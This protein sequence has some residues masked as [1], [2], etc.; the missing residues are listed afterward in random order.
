MKPKQF[1]FWYTKHL[2]TVTVS[3]TN[4]N[5]LKIKHFRQFKFNKRN[6]WEPEKS[7]WK[8]YFWKLNTNDL[9]FI[10]KWPINLLSVS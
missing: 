5:M 3:R 4:D 9:Q 1:I 6:I 10:K 8:F 7:H 2:M